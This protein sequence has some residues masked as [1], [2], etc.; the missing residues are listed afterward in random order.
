MSLFIAVCRL[1]FHSIP[2]VVEYW[3]NTSLT[4]G[5]FFYTTR[6]SL[7]FFFT[8][9]NSAMLPDQK[10]SSETS[11]SVVKISRINYFSYRNAHCK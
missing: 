2:L 7:Y 10:Y 1:L 11:K 4:E 3:T 6:V 9:M 5:I 8:S